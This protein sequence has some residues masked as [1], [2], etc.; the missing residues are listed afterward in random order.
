LYGRGKGR[1]NDER[2]SADVSGTLTVWSIEGTLVSPS[3]ARVA[4]QLETTCNAKGGDV[5]LKLQS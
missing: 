3:T 2:T 4:L 1:R 5:S